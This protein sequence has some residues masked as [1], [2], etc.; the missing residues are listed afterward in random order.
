MPRTTSTP[1]LDLPDAGI[2]G[3]EIP[4]AY[5]SALRRFVLL[6]KPTRK[7]FEAQENRRHKTTW[8]IRGKSFKDIVPYASLLSKTCGRTWG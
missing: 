6:K 3:K 1:P 5:K 2:S 8:K 4:D 7:P